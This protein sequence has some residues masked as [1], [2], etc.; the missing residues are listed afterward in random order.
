MSIVVLLIVLLFVLYLVLYRNNTNFLFILFVLIAINAVNVY[1]MHFL[2]IALGIFSIA[3]INVNNA[4]LEKKKYN[5]QWK[6]VK[7]KFGIEYSDK[8]SEIYQNM[9]NDDNR[10]N[11]YDT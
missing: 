3:Y 8:P 9:F 1:N 10:A 2:L 11:T 4:V 6:N 7:Y 5:N